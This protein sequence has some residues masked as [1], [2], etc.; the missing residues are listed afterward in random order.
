MALNELEAD[1]QASRLEMA[2]TK[3]TALRK[4]WAVFE[5]EARFRGQGIGNIM[6]TPLRRSQVPPKLTRSPNQVTPAND[7]GALWFQ[8]GRHGPGH[9]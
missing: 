8:F 7:R 3:I 2:K 5:G 1:L 9:R 4:Q 6:V